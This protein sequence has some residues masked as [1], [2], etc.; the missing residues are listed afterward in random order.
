[1]PNK[2]KI[3]CWRLCSNILPTKHNLA[4]RGVELET[5][6]IICNHP[7]EDP[8]HVFRDCPLAGEVWLECGLS[9]ITNGKQGQPIKA[10]IADVF[11]TLDD[12]R[13]DLFLMV[14]WS[15]WL[16][17]NAMRNGEE[18]LLARG[19]C[20]RAAHLL[21][22]FTQTV[23]E[24]RYNLLMNTSEI[25]DF[26]PGSYRIFVDGAWDNS[27]GKGGVGV[28]ILSAEGEFKAARA[29]PVPV[30]N[31]SDAVEALAIQEG[32]IM[33]KELQIARCSLYSDN[34]TVVESCADQKDCFT[35]FGAIID[36]VKLLSKNFD[37]VSFCFITRL[38]NGL[39]HK[40]AYVAKSMS[41]S[42]SWTDSVPLELVDM[43]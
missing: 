21:A 23:E 1:M 31:S 3:F 36:G 27:T 24:Q 4:K 26:Q 37:V 22:E 19:I 20:L 32:L 25:I 35:S 16:N 42:L 9:N 41:C 7:V 29:I 11:E 40:M 43:I 34:K 38:L 15:I 17:R 13:R 18:M 39:A 28:V 33:A 2:I 6:C 30:I 8:E 12:H 5:N 14:S 10:W